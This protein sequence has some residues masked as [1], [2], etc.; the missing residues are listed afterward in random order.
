MSL[1]Q[2]SK[3]SKP[4]QDTDEVCRQLGGL[5]FPDVDALH[6]TRQITS[7]RST[8]R[9]WE[10]RLVDVDG[11]TLVS[12][13]G[14]TP[15]LADEAKILALQMRLQ[16][17][18]RGAEAKRVLQGRR[19]RAVL[20]HGAVDR[21]GRLRRLGLVPRPVARRRTPGRAPRRRTTRRAARPVARG[22]D[23]S[24]APS[25]DPQPN[26]APAIGGAS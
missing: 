19:W 6:E 2:T 23:P 18:G 26:P 13:T 25:G 14:K 16:A 22:P 9:R 1:P 7:S 12:A 5:A 8:S 4:Y 20:R 11:R 10:S 3:T 15:E 24:P 17:S 21:A